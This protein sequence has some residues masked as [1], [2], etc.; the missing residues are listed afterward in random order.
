VVGQT[1]LG[2]IGRPEEIASLVRFLLGDESSFMTGETV[3]A[4]GG[5]FMMA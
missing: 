3:S 5:R 2:R 1:P 4:S